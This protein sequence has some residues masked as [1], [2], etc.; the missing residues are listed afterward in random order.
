MSTFDKFL[1]KWNLQ[2]L[3]LA[4]H[5]FIKFRHICDSW[6]WNRCWTLINNFEMAAIILN[7]F[8]ILQHFFDG[9]PSLHAPIINDVQSLH[10]SPQKWIEIIMCS[11]DI[12][13]G[14]KRID[15][16]LDQWVCLALA[17][18]PKARDGHYVS[19]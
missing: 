11:A 15:Q 8:F 9:N 13:P 6:P 7:D 14:K 17:G 2:W 10:L 19:A 18:G 3:F 1:P 12:C 4:S 16:L 5:H